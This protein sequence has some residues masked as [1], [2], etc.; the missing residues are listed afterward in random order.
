[1]NKQLFIYPPT[2]DE[3]EYFLMGAVR[4]SAAMKLLHRLLRNIWMNFWCADTWEW[5]F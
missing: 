3:M 2:Q 4:N 1:M 5:N